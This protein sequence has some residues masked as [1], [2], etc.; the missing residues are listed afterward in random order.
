MQKIKRLR[1]VCRHKRLLEEFLQQ[2]AMPR[3]LLTGYSVSLSLQA[4]PWHRKT[5]W[6]ES[7]FA[8]I[9]NIAKIF[10]W[11][12]NYVGR[13]M[14]LFAFCV[15]LFQI[16]SLFLTISFSVDYM[17]THTD[18][19][20]HTRRRLFPHRSHWEMPCKDILILQTRL[21]WVLCNNSSSRPPSNQSDSLLSACGFVCVFVVSAGEYVWSCSPSPLK[22]VTTKHR[23]HLFPQ[24][25]KTDMNP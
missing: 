11:R 24:Q 8:R 9:A 20:T 18:T 21:C 25:K 22:F 16:L 5:R 13:Q 4:G 2:N 3:D 1:R 17:H 10:V 7:L 12:P 23:K 6:G 15:F 19:H 14:H